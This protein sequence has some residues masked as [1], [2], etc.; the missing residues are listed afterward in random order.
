M[1]PDRAGHRLN[2][3][4]QEGVRFSLTT[5]AHGAATAT[6]LPSTHAEASPGEAGR[7]D[8]CR[9]CSHSPCSEPTQCRIEEHRGTCGAPSPFTPEHDPAR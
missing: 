2:Y 7:D 8:W 6:P 1:R 4:G 5:R 9:G 3:K